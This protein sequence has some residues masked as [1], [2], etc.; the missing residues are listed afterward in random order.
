MD[1]LKAIIII[2]VIIIVMYIW[3][4]WMIKDC[5][6][7]VI[8]SKLRKKMFRS[9]ENILLTYYHDDCSEN[10][11]FE[12][13]KLIFKHVIDKNDDLK[14]DY[15]SIDILLE[16]YLIELNS[17]NKRICNLN[18]PDVDIL[19][20]YLLH[21]IEDFKQNN[22]MEQIKGANNILLTQLLES[23]EKGEKSKFKEIVNQ[24]AMEIKVL[25]DNVFEKEKNSK[26]QN[27][28]S[29]FSII[30]SLIYSFLFLPRRQSKFVFSFN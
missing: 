17:Q 11:C 28:I 20:K 16:K 14:R 4:V 27:A 24:L 19:K 13:V 26:K 25:Q 10:L 29:V 3:L 23:E 22:P 21:M 5:M 30:L 9:L 2:S 6:D 18:I 8:Y 7:T 1:N 15:S 12:E